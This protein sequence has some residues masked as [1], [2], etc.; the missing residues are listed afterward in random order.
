MLG[1]KRWTIHD[2]ILFV[3]FN[4]YSSVVTAVSYYLRCSF[5]DFTFLH[6]QASSHSFLSHRS[7]PI[8]IVPPPLSPDHSF[9]FFWD[10]ILFSLVLVE[11]MKD[12]HLQELKNWK[13]KCYK[14]NL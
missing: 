13:M 1:G 11:H 14:L 2:V 8:D 9:L 5:S 3:L 7:V 12:I 4:F 6:E 10:I